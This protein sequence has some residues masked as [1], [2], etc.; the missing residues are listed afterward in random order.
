MNAGYLR[1]DKTS[2]PAALSSHQVTE[3]ALEAAGPQGASLF[4]PQL[5][6]DPE[7][8]PVQTSQDLQEG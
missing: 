7:A 1:R 8:D 4:L 6:I 5:R 3:K 2:C